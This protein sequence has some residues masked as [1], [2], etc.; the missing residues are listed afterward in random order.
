MCLLWTHPKPQLSNYHKEPH[1]RSNHQGLTRSSCIVKPLDANI[2]CKALDFCQLVSDE[3]IFLGFHRMEGRVCVCLCVCVV[4]SSFQLRKSPNLVRNLLVT[5]LGQRSTNIFSIFWTSSQA[6][7]LVFGCR[8]RMM[9]S[10][11]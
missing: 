2:S 5:R 7:D 9:Q 1:G 8:P 6:E 4:V 3:L 11:I 10:N